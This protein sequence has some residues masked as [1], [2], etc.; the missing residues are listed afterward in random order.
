[1]YIRNSRRGPGG[2][3]GGAGGEVQGL[4][5]VDTDV[6][7]QKRPGEAG[8]VHGQVRGRGQHAAEEM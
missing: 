1:M 5:A 2:A 6:C 7:G 4:R 3:S 8:R